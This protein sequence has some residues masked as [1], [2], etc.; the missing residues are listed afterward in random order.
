MFAASGCSRVV[1]SRRPD[2]RMKRRALL[3]W[4]SDVVENS[5]C[6]PQNADQFALTPF[7]RAA[8]RQRGTL[9][10]V[11]CGWRASV[12]VYFPIMRDVSV[13]MGGQLDK[14]MVHWQPAKCCIFQLFII[15]CY[16]ANKV[17]LLLLVC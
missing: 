3:L 9:D 1:G 2:L 5:C 11:C 7:R 16:L 8:Q 17:L 10:I 15:I 4:Y 12:I 14:R 13:K 6:C